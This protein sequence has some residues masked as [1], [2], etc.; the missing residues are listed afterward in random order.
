MA[1]NSNNRLVLV[2]VGILLAVVS[3][4]AALYLLLPSDTELNQKSATPEETITPANF[5]ISVFEKQGYQQLN[6]QLMQAG[7]L[8]VQPPSNVGKANPFL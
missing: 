1:N 6:R 4:S 3:A 2:L 8:P 7:V 5:D